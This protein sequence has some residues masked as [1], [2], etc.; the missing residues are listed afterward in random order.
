MPDGC[1]RLA[2]GSSTASS[3]SSRHP[4]S[5]AARAPRPAAAASSSARRRPRRSSAKRSACRWGTRR[6][7]PPGHPIW[8][9]M[10]RRS[11][12]AL[13]A[14]EQRGVTMK[15]ILTDAAIHNAMVTHAAFGG[16]TNLILHLP[17]IAHAA[18]LRRPTAQR[19]DRRQPPRAAHRR[20]AAQRTAAPSDDSGL[21]RR[22][23]SRGDAAPAP[24]RPARHARADGK[25]RD[26][27]RAAR[28]L[29]GVRAARAACAP[30][31]NRATASIPTT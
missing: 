10:A 21:S 12:R 5:A 13:M 20:R 16:S 31:C 15:D 6:S 11:A 29:G 26:A 1:R 28:R 17:A 4:S 2:C 22:R 9:D 23:R 19:L 24:R 27:R 14:L 3:R 25:R 18:G 30:S 8:L 7:R